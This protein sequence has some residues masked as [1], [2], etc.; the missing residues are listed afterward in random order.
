LLDVHHGTEG[1]VGKV[2]RPVLVEVVVMIIMF[3]ATFN[4]AS[5]IFWRKGL[6]EYP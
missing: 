6:P 1:F 5:V 2:Y 4:Y 3:N